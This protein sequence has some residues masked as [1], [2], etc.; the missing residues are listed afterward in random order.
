MLSLDQL[1]L[2]WVFPRDTTI[3]FLWKN[4]AQRTHAS[5]ATAPYTY[6]FQ[7]LMN[8]SM[9]Q[10]TY[11]NFL[12]AAP[13]V[14][15][16][17][18]TPYLTQA[19]AVYG[20]NRMYFDSL[21]GFA[22]MRSGIDT[23]SAALYYHNRTD[24]G[25]HTYGNKNDIVYSALG[26]IWIPRVYSNANSNAPLSSGTSVQSSIL[27]NNVGQSVDTTSGQMQGILPVPGKFLHYKNTPTFQCVAGDAKDPYSYAWSYLFGGY[28]SDNPLLGGS[29]TKV[30]NTLNSYRYGKYYSFDDIPLYNKLTQGDYSWAAGARYYRTVSTPWLNGVVNKV[31]RTVAMITDPSPYVIV[32]D[33]VQKDN[34]VNN[35][36]WIAQLA[37]DLT[38]E[39]TVVNLNDSNYRNDIIFREPAGTG[40]RRFLVRILNNTG[41]VSNTVPAY[42]DSIQNPVNN[43]SPN[44]KLPRLVVESN[45][46]DPKFKIMF[47]AY[48]NGDALPATNW[49]VSR[50]RLF[51]TNNGIT[52]TIAFPVDTTGRTNIQLF[53]GVLPLSIRLNGMLLNKS[54]AKINFQVSEQINVKS[55][56]VEKSKDGSRFTSVS[57]IKPTNSFNENYSWYDST[58]SDINYYRIKS[59][60]KDGTVLYS[61]SIIL[62]LNK[63]QGIKIYPNPLLNNQFYVQF[64]DTEVGNFEVLVSDV[65]GKNIF[66]KSYLV[67]NNQLLQLH[68]PN[69]GKGLYQV[70]I[71][72]QSSSYSTILLR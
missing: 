66:K 60:A 8:G 34:S 64:S 48:N 18:N 62:K 69:I 49:N 24:L 59:I 46:I 68:L 19:Q 28:T 6:Y 14:S 57:F 4:Y 20:N 25:G 56:Q 17:T 38:I 29:Y 12:F 72:G 40:N 27:I 43:L 26:R 33:D 21:G 58:L 70:T 32:A 15:D 5:G 42:V 30:M 2:K 10:G 47:F 54:V 71:A 7:N 13:F 39:N 36:K 53:D 51:I 44:N 31:F 22:V 52:K 11:W 63:A 65:T 45:S 55:Y 9:G 35:Y 50:D 16:Y 61:N 41:A 23:L 37:N 67:N 3:D 1:A